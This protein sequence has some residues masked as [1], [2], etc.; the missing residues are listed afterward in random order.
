MLTLPRRKNGLAQGGNACPEETNQRIRL[1]NICGAA[2]D[3]G[4]PDGCSV[5]M[6]GA[7]FEEK[8]ADGDPHWHLL[9]SFEDG[10]GNGIRA[11]TL[12]TAL[13]KL[14]ENDIHDGGVRTGKKN[15][16]LRYLCIPSRRKLSVDAT[17]YV[18][19]NFSIPES[20]KEQRNKG[21]TVTR[22]NNR[23]V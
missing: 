4:L 13:G 6:T 9:F 2:I 22:Y 1:Y 17:P 20:V 12:K 3:S 8:H 23:S 18:H 16:F 10:S 5:S 15:D 11:S 21:Q 14:Q 7:C 19:T